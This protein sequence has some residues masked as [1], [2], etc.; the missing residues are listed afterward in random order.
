MVIL[1]WLGA[2]RSE[3][4]TTDGDGTIGGLCTSGGT[5]TT[6]GNPATSSKLNAPGAILLDPVGSLYATEQGALRKVAWPYPGKTVNTQYEISSPDGREQCT[7]DA[8]G[9][10][11]KTKRHAHRGYALRLRVRLRRPHRDH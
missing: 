5:L 3:S 8:V 2:W 9:R 11:I 4:G 1:S 10:H 6:E 7:F